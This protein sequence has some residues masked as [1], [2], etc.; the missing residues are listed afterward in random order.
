[1]IDSE[2]YKNLC[3]HDPRNPIFSDLHFEGDDDIPEPRVD[4]GCDNCFYRRDPL[5]M[6]II[7]LRGQVAHFEGLVRKYESGD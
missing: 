2:I 1:M 5:S 4:C 3:H 7:R 6:E